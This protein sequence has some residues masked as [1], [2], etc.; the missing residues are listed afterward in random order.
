AGGPPW[1]GV[2][3]GS[4]GG[5]VASGVG[6]DLDPLE[7][8]GGDGLEQLDVLVP[9]QEAGDKSGDRLGD[10][11]ADGLVA[12]LL[13]DR[14]QGRGDPGQGALDRLAAGGA[15]GPGLLL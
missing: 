15:D 6:H 4:G 12:V 2:R 13:E 7:V 9:P 5:A 11:Q 8:A 10:D 3:P 14:P 1:E